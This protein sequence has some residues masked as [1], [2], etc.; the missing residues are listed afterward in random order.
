MSKHILLRRCRRTF[1]RSSRRRSR[2]FSARFRSRATPSLLGRSPSTRSSRA[3]TMFC[4]STS[5]RRSFSSSSSA[6]R[7]ARVFVFPIISFYFVSPSVTTFVNLHPN[8][9]NRAARLYFWRRPSQHTRT[10][11]VCDG[12]ACA[13]NVFVEH[14]ALVH[15]ASSFHPLLIFIDTHTLYTFSRRS[16]SA[17]LLSGAVQKCRARVFRFGK[18]ADSFNCLPTVRLSSYC[19]CPKWRPCSGMYIRH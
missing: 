6:H 8:R 19:A 14:F 10:L 2:S 16:T 17:S 4:P 11:C 12:N 18:R 7:L 9:S 5:R 15:C 1:A 13:L 3:S